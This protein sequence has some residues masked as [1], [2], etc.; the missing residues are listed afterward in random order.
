MLSENF[1]AFGKRSPLVKEA[2]TVRYIFP[3]PVTTSLK[4]GDIVFGDELE[5]DHVLRIDSL[6]S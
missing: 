4:G 6:P 5:W 3:H 2:R 1:A